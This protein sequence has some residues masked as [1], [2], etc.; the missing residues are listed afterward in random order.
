MILIGITG[1]IHNGKTT[2]AGDL[3]S[4]VVSARHM[5]SYEVIAGVADS[6]NASLKTIPSA[7]DI[8][9]INAWLS[10]LPNIFYDQLHIKV[11]FERVKLS[12]PEIQSNPDDYKKLFDYLNEL[13]AKPDLCRQKIAES[14]KQ[15]FRPFLQ[16]LGGYFIQKVDPN[17]WFN[18]IIRQSRLEAVKK[19]QLF[20]ASGVRFPSEAK[21]VRSVGGL[22]IEIS[23]PS[24]PAIDS[25]D[26]T[27][28]QRSLIKADVTIINNGSLEELNLCA[29]QIMTD[30]DS[31]SLKQSYETLGFDRQ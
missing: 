30:L 3:S 7:D 28:R 5:E 15:N 17:I 31:G 10:Q 21:L 8:I 9:S 24:E 26:F 22:I 19:T 25:A 1:G 12:L 4:R 23:R 2:L 20:T 16:W 29:A 13:R 27:E 6:L 18:E 14:N 11:S